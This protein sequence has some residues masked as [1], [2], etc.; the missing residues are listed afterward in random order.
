MAPTKGK[1]II[2]YISAFLIVGSFL[3]ILGV[4]NASALLGNYNKLPDGTL[5]ETDW[6][7]LDDDFLNRTGAASMTGTLSI[8]N[9][10]DVG[11]VIRGDTSA[12]YISSGIFG[13]NAGNGNFYFPGVLGISGNVGVGKTNPSYQL[14]VLGD[15]NFSGTLRYNGAPFTSSKWNSNLSHIYFNTGNVGIGTSAPTQK[16]H[17]VGD[18]EVGGLVYSNTPGSGQ[19]QALTTVDYV[20]AMV[21]G[22]STSTVGFWTQNLNGIYNSSLGNVGIGT[23]SSGKKLDIIDATKTNTVLVIGRGTQGGNDN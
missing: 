22:S 8:T 3:F 7:N 5:T 2:N 13:S 4:N 19:T 20:N 17:V 16:L 6:N 18:V 12:S 21:S 11:G 14:D 1:N 10:L 23:T 9:S 15:I